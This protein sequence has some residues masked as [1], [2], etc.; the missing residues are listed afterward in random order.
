MRPRHATRA[1]SLRLGGPGGAAGR[2]QSEPDHGQRGDDD[3]TGDRGEGDAA[4]PPRRVRL[5][6][7]HHADRASVEEPAGGDPDRA[8][9]EHGGDE[10]DGGHER[11]LERA[12]AE[13]VPLAL[14]G[15][16]P[17]E[18]AGGDEAGQHDRHRAERGTEHR[19]GGHR[20]PDR[21]LHAV[22]H[23]CRLR[24]EELVGRDLDPLLRGVGGLRAQRGCPADVLVQS[25]PH[26]GRAV[27]HRQRIEEVVAGAR[28]LGQRG[29]HLVVRHRCHLD[30]EQ[31]AG[32]AGSEVGREDGHTALVQVVR[33]HLVGHRDDPHELD[34]L[35]TD[36]LDLL[37]E[38]GLV[39][40][41]DSGLQEDALPERHR[42]GVADLQAADHLGQGRGH[43]HLVGSG[44]QPA[45]HHDRTVHVDVAAVGRPDD[46]PE[47]R[48]AVRIVHVAPAASGWPSS[49]EIVS[50]AET[51]TC[52]TPG[53]DRMTLSISRVAHDGL[54][55]T[56]PMS[57]RRW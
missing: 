9:D 44:R 47:D 27:R 4:Q 32:V 6:D 40:A 14:V 30:V 33:Q 55:T 7:A 48:D 25:G 23:P 11:P 52:S 8:T 13:L 29:D 49:G 51:V 46:R 38:V 12:D 41:L 42:R 43:D 36:R 17:P 19:E 53:R 39:V 54:I 56:S 2:P 10:G 22:R 50:S 3:Q 24:G 57:A 15:P 45:L 18:L 28:S 37:R 16:G 34:L 21:L 35:D 20:R 31:R 26:V 1:T 5:D